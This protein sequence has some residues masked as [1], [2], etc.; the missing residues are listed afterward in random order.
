[1]DILKQELMK[2]RQSRAEDVGGK[3]FFKRSEIEQKRLQRL[4]EEEKREAEA[5]ALRQKQL[6][7]DQR[8]NESNS[9]S[10]QN[11]KQEIQ[12]SKAESSSAKSLV[13]EKNIDDLN[14]PKQEV[15][16]RLRFLKQPVTLFGEDDEARLDRLK[17]VLKAGLFEVDDS[18][19]T[20][21]QTNDFLRDIVELKKR[22]KSGILSDRKR[23]SMDDGGEDKEGGAD[24]DLSGDGASSGVDHDK[25]L[26]R[27]KANF[28]ELCDEDKILVFFKKLLNEWNQE[29]DEMSEPEKR[30]AKGKSMV[31]T[32]K[33]CARYL[34]PLF[35]FCRKKVL[36]DD[37][38]QALM[39]VVECCMKRDY[40]AAMD[41]Y[42]K[43][44]IGNAPWP[45]GVT[46]VGIHERS[47]REK[48]Y[49]N[50]VAHIMNDETT[51]KYL[52]SIKRLMTFAQRRYPTMPSKAVEFNSLANG[53]DLQSLL[54]EEGSAGG[55]PNSEERLLLMPASKDD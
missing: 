15:I 18:D 23:K 19:M 11:S 7:Q 8:N 50:S 42:I 32:F 39:L 5:K 55:K 13:E 6:Q 46:M 29:L 1:M 2:K 48:I 4:R 35:K 12:K 28:E 22:Q 17:F 20:E 25:D 51:R 38:R 52:Q 34:N 3:K 41:H 16:R 44:A 37:I 54:A 33:Q 53:S 49:T 9:S 43:L 27:M 36:P 26:K 40:L 30:T 24:E 45:I 47:A 14:L 10:S 21:G 31:A